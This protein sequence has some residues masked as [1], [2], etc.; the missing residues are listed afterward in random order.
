ML[1]PRNSGKKKHISTADPLGPWASSHLSE[2]PF[3]HPEKT[4]RRAVGVETEGA[5]LE[6]AQC[7][8]PCVRRL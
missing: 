7:L 8:G 5:Y 6:P 1:S 2:T 3:P 4:P